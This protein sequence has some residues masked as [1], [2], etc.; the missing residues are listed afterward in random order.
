MSL[1]PLQE[2]QHTTAT[3]HD[4]VVVLDCGAQYTKVIDRR[5]REL[6]AESVIL[7]V[8]VDVETIRQL[9][10]K[11][12]ILSGGPHSVTDPTAPRCSADLFSLGVPVLGI[13]YGMQ[14]MA[15]LLGGE[16]TSHHACEYGET[17]IQINPSSPV[18]QD[19]DA[20][21][22]VLMSHG[23]SVTRLPE[24]FQAVGWSGEPGAPESV[25]AAIEN[26]TRHFYAFQFH[27]EVDLTEN[28]VQMLK[29]FLFNVCH[30]SGA[31]T[32]QSRLDHTLDEIRTQVGTKNALV[33]VSGGVDSTVTAALLLKALTPEQV[34]AVHVDSGF[35]RH[36]ESR[37][38][39]E[40]L[41]ALGLKH[42]RHID[43]TDTF[44]N[45]TT[46]I[47]G[48]LTPP[49]CQVTDPETKRR[50]IGDTFVAIV[51]QV[52]AEMLDQHHIPAEDILLAQGTLRPDL[53]ES[54]NRD[55]SQS[56]HVIKTHHN[57]VPLIQALR[58]EG[59]VIEPNRDW[60][61]DEVRQIGKMLGLPDDLVYRQ[62]FPGPGLAIRMICA[63][64]PSGLEDYDQVQADLSALVATLAQAHNLPL[65]A[66]IAP[67]RSVGVQG[68]GRSYR[69][70]AMLALETPQLLQLNATWDALREISQTI[71]NRLSAINRVAI[72]LTRHGL[73]NS[74]KTVT[75]LLLAPEHTALLRA[76]DHQTTSALLGNQS[77]Q[78]SPISQ[79]LTVLIPVAPGTPEGGKYSAVVRAVVTNDFMTARAARVGNMGDAKTRIELEV[80]ALQRLAGDILAAQPQIDT[81]FY[82]ITGKP[83]ATVEWE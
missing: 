24:G 79:L 69:H 19:L 63:T 9:N 37:S 26:P 22:M 49:L 15:Q 34:F 81:V 66:V 65:Q 20:H 36:D 31:F 27:P 14:L 52:T 50:I 47:D 80:S 53:I 23:D 25:L 2:R 4:T 60:H 3:H 32:L 71:T 11:G 10:P 72:A 38:V 29:H 5:I 58:E 48:T 16:V 40:A 7:P 77:I 59:R 39:C 68:D 44:L 61:K 56:A 35:M 83:P 78:R 57:D 46:D 54:G 17:R 12:I 33:L 45:A 76:I 8:D 18:F 62:P 30:V 73:P 42:L 70:L 43:A 21:Q 75:P 51:N 64:Q 74:L 55:V 1:T 82:D 13:C 67:I 41:K 28:G 6:Q